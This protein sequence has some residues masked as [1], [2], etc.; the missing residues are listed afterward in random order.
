MFFIDPWFWAFLATLGWAAAGMA[1]STPALGHR[2]W[3]GIPI[4]ALC[5]IPRVVLVLPAIPQARLQSPLLV[6]L[7]GLVLVVSLVFGSAALRI[8][9]FTAPD[10]DEPLR[11]DGLYAVVRHPVMFCDAFWPLGLSLMFGSVIG[12]VLTPVWLLVAWLITF[13]EEKLL[14]REYGDR[15]RAFQQRVPRIIPPVWRLWRESQP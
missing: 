11:T 8:S 4:V 15:Y 9:P 14:V 7:G 6:A 5:E 2:L 10:V 3:L 13:P 12:I 1:I